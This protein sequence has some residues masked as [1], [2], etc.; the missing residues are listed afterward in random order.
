[1]SISP[2]VALRPSPRGAVTTFFFLTGFIAATW[3][4]R[5]P[6]AA[7]ALSLSTASLGTLL[8][9]GG[10]GSL[11]A[12]QIVG[13]LIERFGSARVTAGFTVLYALALSGLA[14]APV[15]AVLGLSLFLYGFTAGAADVAMNAQGVEVERRFAKTIMGSL[16]GAW[17]VGGLAGAG[18]GAAVASAGIGLVPHFLACSVVCIGLVLWAR[19]GQIPDHTAVAPTV[20]AAPA[21]SGKRRRLLTVPPK[22]LRLLGV[23]AFCGAIGEGAASDW[24]ALFIH[25][26]L[27]GSQ[28]IA[29]VGFAA[30]SAT[31]LTGRFAGDHL[32]QRFGRVPVV[33]IAGVLAVLGMFLAIVPRTVPTAILGFG[34]LGLGISVV[35]PTAFSA[36]GAT[37]GISSGR[38][39]AMVATIGYAGF[40][41]GPPALGWFAKLTSLEW[42]LALVGAFLGLI[43]LVAPALRQRTTDE[44]AG[45][46]LPE[47]AAT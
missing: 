14:L 47:S 21:T 15:P 3:V 45:Q 9:F 28:G 42:S 34:V 24:S 7:Q 18:L 8:L 5:I 19:R 11:T 16:H 35:M 38:A 37:P 17:S 32:I 20:D 2:R 46:R 22:A 10:I 27:G 25:K 6:A 31:M 30:F 12:L 26:S 39:V 4:T 40:L 29:A 1:M 44:T 36:A 23:I 13:R 41:L 33:R 43:V